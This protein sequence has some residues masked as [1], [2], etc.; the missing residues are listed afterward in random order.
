MIKEKK[1]DFMKKENSKFNFDISVLSLNEL[2]K[3]YEEITEF[4]QF[5]NDSKIVSEEKTE[6]K[7]E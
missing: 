5:L 6:G 2:I 4:L 3:L 7:D 1:G